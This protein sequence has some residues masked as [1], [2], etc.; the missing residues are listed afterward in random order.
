MAEKKT[1]KAYDDMIEVV[2][3]SIPKER[4]ASAL[5]RRT[6]DRAVNEMTRLLFERLADD[7]LR[8]EEKLKAVL[9]LLLQQR[10]EIAKGGSG[11]A[12]D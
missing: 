4:E 1:L 10:E 8:H 5:Y 6:A 11:G 2:V 9:K 3:R 12:P 7:E